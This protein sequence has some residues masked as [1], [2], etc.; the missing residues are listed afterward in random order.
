MHERELTKNVKKS[1]TMSTTKSGPKH[2][3]DIELC[4]IVVEF[5]T[6]LN[7]ITRKHSRTQP[8]THSTPKSFYAIMITIYAQTYLTFDFF[9]FFECVVLNPDHQ[10]V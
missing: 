8:Y 4:S 2:N 5:T 6:D 7:G 9:F 10:S 3:G 1:R